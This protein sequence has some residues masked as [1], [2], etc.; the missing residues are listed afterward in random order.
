MKEGL[1]LA[2]DLSL[3]NSA[4]S[5]LCS[6]LALLHSVSYFFFLYRSPSSSLCTVFDSI[7][8]NIDEV[9][10]IVFDDFNVHHK[11]WLAYFGGT[12]KPGELSYNFSIS[13]DLTQMVNF[14][15]RI[16]DCDSHSPAL[17]DLFLSSDASVY[18]TVAFPP[19][20]NTDHVVVSVSIDF[21]S[22]SKRDAPFDR[23]AYDY[24]RADWDGLRDHLRDVPWE[25]IFKL[26]ASVAAREFCE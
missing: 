2:R 15:T 25:D 18:S 17:L 16:P 26:D 14:P 23:I 21:L 12:D 3:E 8:S 4:D 11:D 13:N 19:L 22:N 7:S 10:S 6:R 20:E 24:S 1:P 9:L 5:Y